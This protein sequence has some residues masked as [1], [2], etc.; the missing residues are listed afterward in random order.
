MKTA[1]KVIQMLVLCLAFISITAFAATTPTT[2]DAPIIAEISVYTDNNETGLEF[3]LTLPDTIKNALDFYANHERGYNQVGY[4]S[5]IWGEYTVDGSTWQEMPIDNGGIIN[6]GIRKTVPR[7]DINEDKTV[8]FHIKFTG[9]D[10]SLGDWESPWSNVLTSNW[11]KADSIIKQLEEEGQIT[12][13]INFDTG[14]ATLKPD[15]AGIISE[16]VAALQARPNISVKLEGHTDNVGSAAN[17]KILSDDRANAVM[18]AI[19]AEGIDKGRLSAEGFGL[20][21]PIAGNDT[22]EGRARNRRVELVKQ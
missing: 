12:L 18:A 3:T 7:D 13:Y 1:T 15:A 10:E 21:K 22:E 5:S 4:V 8:Q 16:I 17:N 6:E 9:W 14:K 11:A 19:I 2:F 20:E